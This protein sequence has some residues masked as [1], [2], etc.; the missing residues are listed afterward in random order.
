MLPK[1]L[2][3]FLQWI[4]CKESGMTLPEVTK[5]AD[6]R[7]IITIGQDINHSASHGRVKK[8]KHVGFA[9]AVRHITGSKTI[10][11]ILNRMGHCSSYEDLEAVDT[12]LA[13]EA[14]VRSNL[15]GVITPSNILPGVFIQAAADKNDINE[16]TL[17]GKHAT[18]ATTLVL[19]QKGQFGPQPQKKALVEHTRKWRTLT[20]SDGCQAC[21]NTTPMER[22]HQSKSSCML[23][24]KSGTSVTVH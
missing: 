8:P 23:S 20:A 6:E 16:E 19:Y 3:N 13:M 24:S 2:Y 14:V 22:N 21:L 9:V 18:H 4:I 15:F 10:I 7:H 12:S 5:A 17:D 11:N 1:S